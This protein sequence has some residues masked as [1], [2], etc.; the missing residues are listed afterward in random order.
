[1]GFSLQIRGS[2]PLIIP[3]DSA[4]EPPMPRMPGYIRFSA[5]EMDAL[6]AFIGAA[7]VVDKSIVSGKQRRDCAKGKVPVHKFLTNDGYVVTARE[8]RLIADAMGGTDLF[9]PALLAQH[10]P[11]VDPRREDLLS[12][13]RALVA[14]WVGYNRVAAANDGYTIQ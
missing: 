10:V 6:C 7:G 12:R 1:M 2:D 13:P 9:A 14:L 8:A 11:R 4:Y 5:K 3:P